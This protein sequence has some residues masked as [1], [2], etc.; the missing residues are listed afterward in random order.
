MVVEER[1]T[2]T[3]CRVHLD[4]ESAHYSAE[5]LLTSKRL[6]RWLSWLYWL[7]WPRNPP[8]I[9]GLIISDNHLAV[10]REFGKWVQVQQGVL[11]ARTAVKSVAGILKRFG[12]VEIERK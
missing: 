6:N 4:E 9:K 10:A 12:F 3:L 7:G 11:R 5:W 2:G 1:V 8:E